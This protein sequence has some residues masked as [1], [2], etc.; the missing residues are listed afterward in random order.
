MATFMASLSLN[1]GLLNLLPIPVLDGGHLFIMTVEGLVRRDFS[2]KMKE[3]MMMAASAVLMLLMVTVIYNDLARA[4]ALRENTAALTGDRGLG[5]GDWGKAPS[6]PHRMFY[7]RGEGPVFW[8][9]RRGSRSRPWG[10]S[11]VFPNP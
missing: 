5:I 11:T 7:S 10:T 3:R 2:L 9:P 4:A 8:R 6:P 1:L